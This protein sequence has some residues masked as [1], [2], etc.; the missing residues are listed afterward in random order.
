MVKLSAL[1][2][3]TQTCLSREATSLEIGNHQLTGNHAC[4][5][6]Q[7]LGFASSGLLPQGADCKTSETAAISS[8]I[9]TWIKVFLTNVPTMRRTSQPSE[10][11]VALDAMSTSSTSTARKCTYLV[12]LS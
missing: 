1:G 3:S 5:E 10:A 6:A 12:R 7:R 11:S 2:E 4:P 9:G 8:N